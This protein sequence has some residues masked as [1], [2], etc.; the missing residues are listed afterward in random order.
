MMTYPLDSGRSLV[1]LAGVNSRDLL[2]VV[3]KVQL[4][5]AFTVVTGQHKSV[6]DS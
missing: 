5:I 1:D 6:T 3:C 4:F 2:C